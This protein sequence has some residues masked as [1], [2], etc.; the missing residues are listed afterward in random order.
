MKQFIGCDAHKKYS[1][2]VAM[3]ALGERLQSFTEHGEQEF[4]ESLWARRCLTI[5][6]RLSENLDLAFS[7]D[8]ACPSGSGRS[9]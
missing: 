3:N 2:F 8:P 1:V 9:R 4:R 6:S 5:H 7:T